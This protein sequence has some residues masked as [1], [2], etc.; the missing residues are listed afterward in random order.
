MALSPP[1]RRRA[2]PGMAGVRLVGL[3]GQDL[4]RRGLPTQSVAVSCIFSRLVVWYSCSPLVG[5]GGSGVAGRPLGTRLARLL[6]CNGARAPYSPY[7][8]DTSSRKGEGNGHRQSLHIHVRRRRVAEKI[9]RWRLVVM[10]IPI[11]NLVALGYVIRALRNAREGRALPCPSGTTGGMTLSAGCS[12]PSPRSSTLCRCSS[13][14]SSAWR[15]PGDCGR[16]VCGRA[17]ARGL[18]WA[19]WWL[20]HPGAISAVRQA[21]QL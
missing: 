2:V 7:R 8:S 1:A 15:P 16:P 10:L 13:P 19:L 21:R 4:S 17:T 9:R 5:T 6:E 11:L 20:Y 12:S 3:H 18:L 14:C